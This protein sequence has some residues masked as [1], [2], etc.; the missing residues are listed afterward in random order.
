MNTSK[1]SPDSDRC[2][3]CPHLFRLYTAVAHSHEPDCDTLACA[4]SIADGY[5]QP[6]ADGRAFI[7]AVHSFEYRLQ[8]G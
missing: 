5:C 8:N 1:L 6:G 2:C 7:R 4:F 3:P